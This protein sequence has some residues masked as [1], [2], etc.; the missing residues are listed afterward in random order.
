VVV[1]VE[2]VR[3]GRLDDFRLVKYVVL[4]ALFISFFCFVEKMYK[5]VK[6]LY[7]ISRVTL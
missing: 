3:K 5:M 2:S 4:F 6:V 1:Q 7:S